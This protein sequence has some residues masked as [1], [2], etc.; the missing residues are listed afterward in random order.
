MVV[1]LA[2]CNWLGVFYLLM[3]WLWLH[4]EGYEVLT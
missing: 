1:L 2:A 3:L 4:M